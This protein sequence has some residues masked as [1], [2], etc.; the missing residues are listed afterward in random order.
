MPAPGEHKTVQSRILVYAQDIGWIY[1]PR[2]DPE[3]RKGFHPE[4]ATPEDRAR[5]S[6]LYFGDL[7]HKQVRAFNPKKGS[8]ESLIQTPRLLPNS[9]MCRRGLKL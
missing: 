2:E 7:L 4:G 9:S 5:P 3:R 6:S 8:R 1:V